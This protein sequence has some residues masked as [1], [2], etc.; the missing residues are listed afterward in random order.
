MASNAQNSAILETAEPMRVILQSKALN[1]WWKELTHGKRS[2]ISWDV[3]T[4]K[5]W[6]TDI[7]QYYPEEMKEKIEEKAWNR[8]YKKT[9]TIALNG[10]P[11]NNF[12]LHKQTIPVISEGPFRIPSKEPGIPSYKDFYY[13]RRIETFFLLTQGTHLM[14]AV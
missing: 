12:F 1:Q 13:I 2:G 8:S 5:K 14:S 6:S 7:L 11:S 4:C 3:I 9:P 10:N